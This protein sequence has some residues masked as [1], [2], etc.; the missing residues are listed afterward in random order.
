MRAV[1]I[2][3]GHVIEF[4]G[5]LW[6]VLDTQVTYVGKRGAYVQVKMRNLQDQH[7]E[8][9]RFSSSET[10][11]KAFVESRQ[12]VYLY[13]DGRDYVFMDPS[14]GEQ[15]AI[16]EEM[17]EGIASYLA[18]N[19]EVAVELCDGRPVR[20]Q[21]PAS[22]VLEVTRA[23]PAVRGD[24]ATGVTKPVE[25]ETGLVIKVPGYIQQGEKVRVDTRTGEFLGRA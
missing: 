11:E 3:K 4:R 16:G 21:L 6:L 18:Y 17:L 14:S 9:Q 2:R 23:E 5:G 22:V 13:Q 12:M 10:V 25:L 8:T 20:V 19:C 24:T 7:I 1:E 15:L